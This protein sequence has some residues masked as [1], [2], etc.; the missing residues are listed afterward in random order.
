MALNINSL[1]S[2]DGRAVGYDSQG[3]GFNPPL[4]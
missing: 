3:Q 4:R 1:D 2:S